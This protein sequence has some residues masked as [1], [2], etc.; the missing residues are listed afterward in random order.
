LRLAANSACAAAPTGT[1]IPPGSGWL[2]CRQSGAG[3]M[4]EPAEILEILTAAFAGQARPV[5]PA[6]QAP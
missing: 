5:H 3:R 4:A 6:I 1:I 2:S